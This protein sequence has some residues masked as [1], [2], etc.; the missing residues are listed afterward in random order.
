MKRGYQDVGGIILAAADGI[1]R[2]YRNY[3]PTLETK[4]VQM[5]SSFRHTNEVLQ[6]HR[7]SGVITGWNQC[8]VSLLVGGD[9]RMI[10]VWDAHTESQVM[11]ITTNSESSVT[12]IV[13]DE[14]LTS[15]FLASF[16]DG[17]SKL[18]GHFSSGSW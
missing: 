3:D 11:D 2:F 4:L 16:A 1:L 9:S 7:G 5:V 15:T 6:V 14:G 12:A 8:C 18:S 10:R 17:M 13:S